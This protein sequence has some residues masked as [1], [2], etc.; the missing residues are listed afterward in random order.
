MLNTSLNRFSVEQEVRAK[1][2]ECRVIAANKG[3]PIDFKVEFLY[4]GTKGG[5]YRHSTKTI[6]INIGLA[7]LS[8]ANK[9]HIL[10]DTCAHECC[11]AAQRQHFAPIYTNKTIKHHDHNFYRLGRIIF[12]KDF[13]R[14][15]NMETEGVARKH[16]RP[17]VY[18]CKCKEHQITKTIHNK[19]LTGKSYICKDCKSRISL[20]KT[21]NN[22]N[23]G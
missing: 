16:A 22:V 6:A 4:R 17:Y 3:Y 18:A 15:H 11:H 12:N 13:S 19:I 23:Y 5:H 2:Q 8:E 10:E 7:C 21:T 20:S 9:K 14:C 1:L